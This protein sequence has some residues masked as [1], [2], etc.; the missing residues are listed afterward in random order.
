MS[1]VIST[2]FIVIVVLST[3][4]PCHFFSVADHGRAAHLLP[5]QENLQ[6]WLHFWWT[7]GTGGSILLGILAVAIPLKVGFYVFRRT[8][9]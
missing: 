7:A 2:L 3:A 9:F 5:R 4:L 1:L 6:W 8:E